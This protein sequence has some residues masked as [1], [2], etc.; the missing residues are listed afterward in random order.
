MFQELEYVWHPGSKPTYDLD[1]YTVYVRYSQY[2]FVYSHMF[3]FITRDDY[4][5]PF[6]YTGLLLLHPTFVAEHRLHLLWM[7]PTRYFAQLA[8]VLQKDDSQVLSKS[9][10]LGQWLLVVPLIG[11]RWYIIFQLAVYTTY[12]PPIL[13]FGGLF[14]TYHLLYKGNQK[15][16][17]TRWW[18]HFL[19]KFTPEPWGRFSIL[20]I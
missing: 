12:I 6:N 5:T 9:R 10:S 8:P 17:L 16:T 13:P 11:G 20:T 15:Q 1:S 19:K 3:V 4:C 14:A 7:K 18:C 2:K